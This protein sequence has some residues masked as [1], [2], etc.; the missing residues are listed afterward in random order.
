M[1]WGFDGLISDYPRWPLTFTTTNM[2]FLAIVHLMLSIKSIHA[3][4]LEISC[5]QSF[6]SLTSDNLWPP[7]NNTFVPLNE[8]HILTMGVSTIISQGIPLTKL[9]KFDSDDLNDLW[10]PPNSIRFSLYKMH[11]HCQVWRVSMLPFWGHPANNVFSVWPPMTPDNL[12][13]PP[14]I[15]ESILLI[16][17]IHL[18]TMESIHASCLEI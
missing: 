16:N 15:L 6:Q 9:S 5:Q 17:Y 18:L 4:S 13:P 2:L 3:V 12:W 1:H 7:P 10:P 8:M 11:L 14:R